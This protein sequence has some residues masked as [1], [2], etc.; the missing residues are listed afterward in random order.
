MRLRLACGWTGGTAT[1]IRASTM[2]A[3]D[4]YEPA[5]G[6]SDVEDEYESTMPASAG[7][8]PSVVVAFLQQLNNSFASNDMRGACHCP[9]AAA[10]VQHI[11]LLGAA[12]SPRCACVHERRAC[13]RARAAAIMSCYDNEFGRISTRFFSSTPW[14]ST[15]Q[16]GQ[17]VSCHPVFLIMYR[18]LYYR[19]IMM[20]RG[21]VDHA[22]Y[23]ESW[24]A[25]KEM[26]DAVVEGRTDGVDVPSEW[27]YDCLV[28][29]GYQFQKYAQYWSNPKTLSADELG[30][31]Q[32]KTTSVSIARCSVAAALPL[33]VAGLSRSARAGV[34]GARRADAAVRPRGAL[35]RSRVPGRG[36]QPHPV[37]SRTR[38]LVHACTCSP[39]RR[40]AAGPRPPTRR[41]WATLGSSRCAASTFSWATSTPP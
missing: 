40:R 18:E 2:D 39:A 5:A 15:E 30:F 32:R 27:L 24:G 35:A 1:D 17:I 36:A 29:F 10:L 23:V 13:V 25:Y 31:I 34:D 28:E 26:F 4:R 20:M 22:L 6:L 3:Y 38:K 21:S 8:L 14:P 19:H 7:G 37:R 12:S 33:R 9:R 11:H 41:S 16:V